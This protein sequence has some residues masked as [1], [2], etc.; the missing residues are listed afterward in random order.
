[1]KRAKL[2]LMGVSRATQALGLK[3]MLLVPPRPEGSRY[4][5]EDAR[6]ICD[7]V[8]SRGTSEDYLR[9]CL[10][11]F[12]CGGYGGEPRRMESGDCMNR[13]EISDAIKVWVEVSNCHQRSI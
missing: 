6:T 2:A 13:G 12:G 8:L 4:C 1:M 9:T 10:G 3:P 5:F 7:D 11:A